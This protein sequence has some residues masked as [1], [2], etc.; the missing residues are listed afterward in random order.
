M[1]GVVSADDADG[2]VCGVNIAHRDD[3][4][5]ALATAVVDRL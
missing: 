1:M 3:S 5:M 2:T 4:G